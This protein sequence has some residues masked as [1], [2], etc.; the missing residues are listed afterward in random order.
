MRFIKLIIDIFFFLASGLVLLGIGAAAVIM[1]LP[2]VRELEKCFTTQ[3]YSVY[4]CPTSDH[5]VKLKDISPY[6]LH[7]VIVAEDGSFYTHQ[8]FDW[9]EMQE[10][11]ETDLRTGKIRRG[12]STLTQQ[13]A[14]NAFLS[15]EKSVWRKLKEA[16]LAHGIEK[17][18]KKDFI[19]EKYLNVVEFGKD[20]YGVKDAAAHY[21]HKAPSE[22]NP[23]E[24]AF[25]AFLL[26]NPKVYSHS[27]AVGKLSPF[28]HKEIGIIL[29][30]M[31]AYGKLSNE[32]YQT[33]EAQ[34]S[35]F[36][37]TG[38][39]ADAFHGAPSY[40]LEGPAT[41]PEE[42]E[43]LAPAAD[44]ATE[45]AGGEEPPTNA[46]GASENVT[47]PPKAAGDAAP[48]EESAPQNDE[49]APQSD[50]TAPQPDGNSTPQNQTG[51]DSGST[52]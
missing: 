28:A 10:S 14:K 17:H 31:N 38:L 21:F 33:A 34:L 39:N 9:H 40:S 18:Y 16:Y 37:W 15:K 22:L 48:V 6:V 42:P 51:S 1:T 7:A 46:A 29:H 13:L 19:L 5:Y 30:R 27:F 35:N 24:A 45:D 4:L 52:D 3:M 41:I 44:E 47:S 49:T 36:P 2:D 8:G 12:G 26:P 20:I 43:P 25:L 11:F 23:L 50:A 32:G